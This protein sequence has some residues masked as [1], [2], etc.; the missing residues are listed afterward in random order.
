MLIRS[1]GEDYSFLT[2]TEDFAKMSEAYPRYFPT[3]MPARASR[4]STRGFGG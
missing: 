4:P 1:G 2:D 3:N